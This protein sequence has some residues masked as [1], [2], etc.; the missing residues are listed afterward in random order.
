MTRH[1]VLNPAPSHSTDA[2]MDIPRGTELL[3]WYNHSYTSF[4]IPLQCI[5]RTKTVEETLLT[6]LPD[7]SSCLSVS[8]HV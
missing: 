4:G 3:V 6:F 5:A 1:A 8:S 7:F 2:G